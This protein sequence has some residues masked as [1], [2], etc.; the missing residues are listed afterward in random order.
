MPLL[1]LGWRLFFWRGLA[2]TFLIFA[3]AAQNWRAG[4]GLYGP[5]APGLDV[6]RYSPLVA[7]LLVP[8]GMLPISLASVL[9]VLANA[10]VFL[11]AL[12]LW[13]RLVPRS[14]APVSY[15]S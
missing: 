7:G 15:A 8:L 13:L 12:F 14:P 6:F 4:T 2:N 9:W 1:V 10:A 11:T 3:Q 5:V